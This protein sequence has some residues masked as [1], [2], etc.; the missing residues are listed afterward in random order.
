MHEILTKNTRIR[1][2]PS[3]GFVRNPNVE[4]LQLKVCVL[5]FIKFITQIQFVQLSEQINLAIVSAQLVLVHVFF[6][7]SQRSV[8]QDALGEKWTSSG[9]PAVVRVCVCQVRSRALPE[10]DRSLVLLIRVN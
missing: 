7:P 4:A 10:R 1:S 6:K 5:K 9:R 8:A 2:P 3:G